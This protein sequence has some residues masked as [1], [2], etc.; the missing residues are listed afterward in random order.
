M[1]G[2]IPFMEFLEAHNIRK[3][4]CTRNFEQPVNYLLERY[5]NGRLFDPI[6]DRS[7]TPPKPSPQPLLHI[8]SQWQTTGDKL[9][10][11]GDS[12][13][14]MISGRDAG[15]STVLLL[16]KDNRELA[17]EPCTDYSVEQ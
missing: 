15:A 11:V 16:N 12:V 5:L 7:F 3:A 8:A 1:G 9:M 2:L 6:I 13:D 10:M 4:I 14:D 17:K